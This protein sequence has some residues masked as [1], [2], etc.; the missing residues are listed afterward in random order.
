MISHSNSTEAALGSDP[1]LFAIAEEA[2]RWLFEVA[3]P[4]WSASGRHPCGRFAER[5]TMRRGG[6]SSKCVTCSRSARSD[7]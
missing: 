4:L 7:V 1:R 6:Y 2:K 3:A 5:L